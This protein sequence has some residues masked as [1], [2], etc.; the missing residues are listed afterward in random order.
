M[1]DLLWIGMGVLVLVAGILARRGERSRGRLSDDLIRQIE[2]TG[3]IDREDVDPIDVEDIQGHED[4]F[5]S[6]TWDE[7]EDLGDPAGWK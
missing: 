1:N 7:P 3:R 5:W 6:Q 2:S 4:D